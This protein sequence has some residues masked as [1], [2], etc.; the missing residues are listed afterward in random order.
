MLLNNML[1]SNMMQFTLSKC[2]ELL[3]QLQAHTAVCSQILPCWQADLWSM[4]ILLYALLVGCPPWSMAM[5]TCSRYK[6]HA[7]GDI[8]VIP[9]TLAA[10]AKDVAMVANAKEKKVLTESLGK[11]RKEKNDE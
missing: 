8:D 7:A 3:F 6:A 4:G 11:A 2:R 9:P 10:P 5:E 1:I